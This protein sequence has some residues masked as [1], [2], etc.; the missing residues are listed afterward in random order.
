MHDGIQ[1]VSSTHLNGKAAKEGDNDGQAD[2]A[3]EA[4]PG[5]L[6]STDIPLGQRHVHSTHSHFHD[7]NS[8]SL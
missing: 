1:H 7:F 6:E 2:D 4:M 5:T 8:I 3:A